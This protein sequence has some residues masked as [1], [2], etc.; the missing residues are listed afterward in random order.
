MMKNNAGS[1]LDPYDRNY[2]FY[3]SLYIIFFMFYGSGGSNVISSYL[4]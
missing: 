3:V 1:I 2:L 4:I